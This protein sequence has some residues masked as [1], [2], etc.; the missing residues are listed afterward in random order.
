MIR[1]QKPVTSLAGKNNALA[2]YEQSN[3]HVATIKYHIHYPIFMA[4]TGAAVISLMS[5]LYTGKLPGCFSY[6]WPGYEARY[7]GTTQ[8][9]CHPG[10]PYHAH[11]TLLIG[12]Y[13]TRIVTYFSVVKFW[14]TLRASARTVAPESPIPFPQRLWKRVLQN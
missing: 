2:H 10:Q 3:S 5:Y 13:W 7:K 11:N 9:H 1:Q 8:D 4:F 6:K 14:F 12:Q